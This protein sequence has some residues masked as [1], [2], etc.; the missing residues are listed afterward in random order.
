MT[1]MTMK[2][3]GLSLSGDFSP[4][5]ERIRSDL[6]RRRRE[7]YGLPD[8]VGALAA[9]AGA[10]RLVELGIV[11]R[12]VFDKYF[13]PVFHILHPDAFAIVENILINGTAARPPVG[14]AE[15]N[16]EFERRYMG[17]WQIGID[18]SEGR[19]FTPT[20]D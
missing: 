6:L 20:K 16:P 12:S 4:S 5:P 13:W 1:A 2:P 9:H 8:V 10:F 14:I 19:D 11:P 18:L 7:L 3:L 17:R 15:E